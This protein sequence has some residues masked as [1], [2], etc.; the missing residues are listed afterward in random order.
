MAEFLKLMSLFL[1]G[2]K[3]HKIDF[4]CTEKIPWSNGECAAR[5]LCMNMV[6]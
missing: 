2:I 6:I 3:T 5:I 1:M 4:D